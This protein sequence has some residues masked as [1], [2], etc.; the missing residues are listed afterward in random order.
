MF[1]LQNYFRRP[2][3]LSIPDWLSSLARRLLNAARLVVAGE[4]Y[5]LVEV[6]TYYHSGD[7]PDPFSHRDPIQLE[8]GR[9]YFHRTGGVYRSGSFKGLDVTFGDGAA[10]GGILFRGFET[11]EARLVDGPSL[12][13]NHLLVKTGNRT[14][15]SL[16]QSLAKRA[17]WDDGGVIRLAPIDDEARP[18]FTSARVGLSFK[19]VRPTPENVRFLLRPYRFLTEPR[20]I[21][22]GKVLLV[23]A[24]HRAGH[25]EAD[26][27]RLTGCPITA[28]RRH[29][30][31]FREGATTTDAAAFAGKD[32][33]SRELGLL[34]GLGASL[35]D[36]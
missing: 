23:L 15:A 4:P 8:S 27:K 7:H 11:P 12:L 6:E 28:I 20:R 16:D 21:A 33:G 9:W 13:V 10:Y 1:D 24:L 31:A 29:V 25:P 17:A 34:H 18:V 26:I 22:K 36:G 35:G 19:R 3:D 14:V 2:P 30:M 5:R 32:L